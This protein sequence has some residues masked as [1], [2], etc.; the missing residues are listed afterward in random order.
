MPEVIPSWLDNFF[1]WWGRTTTRKV[2]YTLCHVL[3]SYSVMLTAGA[4]HKWTVAGVVAL[5]AIWKEFWFDL[6][7][8]TPETSGGIKGGI[9]DFSGYVAGVGLALIRFSI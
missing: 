7:Y 9:K 4:L 1:R 5:F 8:E 3:I 6:R 2:A